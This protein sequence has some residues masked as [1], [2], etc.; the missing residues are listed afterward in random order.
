M[1]ERSENY[2][3]KK[4]IT[5]PNILSF[6]RL[7]LIPVFV[8]LY[9]FKKNYW[10][11]TL[12]LALSGATDVV[13]GI[14]AR[15][16]HMVSDFGKA[17]DPVADKL[18]QIAMLFCLVTRFPHM[19]IPLV[20]LVIKEI[21]AAV[22]N[23]MAIKKSGEML[24]AVWHGKATTVCLYAMMLIHLVWFGIPALAS[25]ILIGACTV[26]MLLSAVLYSMR[27]IRILRQQKGEAHDE[28]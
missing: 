26:M 13:D 23:L 6:F 16:F 12:T 14:I 3:Q 25:D 27:S 21:L 24:S 5:I 19:M 1:N 11:T 8:W 20:I 28:S 7:C 22:M 18:T 9:C 17:F 10:A 2:Y 4:L 15:R